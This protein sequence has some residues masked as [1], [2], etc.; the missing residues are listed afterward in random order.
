VPSQP[1]WRLKI[2]RAEHHLLDLRHL[3]KRYQEGHHYRAVCPNP[4]RQPTHSGFVLDITEPPD[5]QIAIVLG[6]LLFNVRS[7]LD[8][9]AVAC[10]PPARKRQAGFPIYERPD[11]EEQRKFESMTRGVAPEAMAAT[12]SPTT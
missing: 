4:P 7:A 2:E 12:N 10:A 9:I 6:D 11:D 5:D 8:H 1:S 3:V